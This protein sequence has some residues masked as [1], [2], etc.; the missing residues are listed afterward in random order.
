M[1]IPGLDVEFLDQISA[2]E[3][4]SAAAADATT[5]EAQ[6]QWMLPPAS[7]WSGN[8]RDVAGMNDAFDRTDLNSQYITIVSDGS[9]TVGEG[10]VTKLQ[11][12]Y[13]ATIERGFRT[14]HCSSVRSKIHAMGRRRGM[15]MAAGPFTGNTVLWLQRLLQAAQDD[16]TAGL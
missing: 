12:V 1:P 13:I 6:R 16:P 3:T 2:L 15:G 5:L 14:R 9:Y 10:A 4:T 11:L 8:P 7:A